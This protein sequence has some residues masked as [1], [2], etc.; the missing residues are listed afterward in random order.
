M[1]SLQ[2]VFFAMVTGASVPSSDKPQVVTLPDSPSTDCRLA[3]ASL[4]PNQARL[5]CQVVAVEEEPTSET[6]ATIDAALAKITV[7]PGTS[8]FHKILLTKRAE[9]MVWLQRDEEAEQAYVSL[10]AAYPNDVAI[11]TSAISHLSLTEFHKDEAADYWLNF[12]SRNP[13]AARGIKPEVLSG[14]ILGLQNQGERNINRALALADKLDAIG[15]ETNDLYIDSFV[16]S[17]RFKERAKRS[18]RDGALV[19]LKQVRKPDTLATFAMDKRYR[20]Y[21]AAISWE[22]AG[23][24]QTTWRTW[25]EALA[26]EAHGDVDRTGR[27]LEAIQPYVNAQSLINAYEHPFM[28]G[29]GAEDPVLRRSYAAW[30]EPLAKAYL[31][32]GEARNAERIHSITAEAMSDQPDHIKLALAVQRVALLVELGR[33]S[34]AE[35]LLEETFAN[36]RDVRVSRIMLQKVHTLKLYILL[37][38][39]DI[40]TKDPSMVQMEEW[41]TYELINAI[42]AFLM[43]GKRNEARNA[44]QRRLKMFSFYPEALAYLQ[45]PDAGNLSPLEEKRERLRTNLLADRQ[46]RSSIDRRG[47]ILSRHPILLKDFNL[48]GFTEKISN[49]D[50]ETASR[51]P[52]S[53]RKGK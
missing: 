35:S 29:L 50:A 22:D 21:W 44:L 46:L 11:Q 33:Y 52:Q 14:L 24:R 19:A 41:L 53:G 43:I 34:D 6:L 12:I 27:L 40:P 48:P 16:A 15:Y 45:P 26:I 1:T 23:V 2:F 37:S 38:K 31:A 47:R 4:S 18:D 30:A 13:I 25:F 9:T 10:V 42:D 5:F 28:Q 7:S 3:E 51:D 20:D 39:G 32:A 36:F 8:Q 49:A 17:L